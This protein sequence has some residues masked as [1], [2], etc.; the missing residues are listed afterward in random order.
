MRKV[1]EELWNGNITPQISQINRSTNYANA[2]KMMCKNEEALKSILKDNE[3]ETF[4]KFCECRDEV[5]QY[6]EE[7]IFIKGFRLGARIIIESFCENDGFSN[8]M[9]E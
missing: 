8:E 7:D 4:E 5:D 3:K 6:T 9:N 2:L 1:L